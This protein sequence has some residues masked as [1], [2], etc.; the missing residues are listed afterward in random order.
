[1]SLMSGKGSTRTGGKG[2]DEREPLELAV[3]FGRP[4]K[5]LILKESS[6]D[7]LLGGNECRMRAGGLWCMSNEQYEH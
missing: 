6:Q 2:G 5:R 3:E 4:A 7:R 1:M